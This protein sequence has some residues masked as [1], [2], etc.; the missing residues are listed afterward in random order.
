MDVCFL[1]R[2]GRGRVI[3]GV[4]GRFVLRLRQL[5]RSRCLAMRG[6]A[7]AVASA[8]AIATAVVAAIPVTATIAIAAGPGKRRSSRE[9]HDGK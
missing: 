3:R 1:R 2:R 6:T 8:I 4:V 9:C 5:T 7:V